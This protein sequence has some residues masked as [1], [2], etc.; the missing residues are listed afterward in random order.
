[1]PQ[2]RTFPTHPVTAGKSWSAAGR[3]LGVALIALLL[4]LLATGCSN[5]D[6]DSSTTQT[7]GNSESRSW[8]ELERFQG[9]HFIREGEG[10]LIAYA[11]TDPQ[12]P[13]CTRLHERISQGATPNVEWRW[14]PVGFLGPQSRNDAAALLGEAHADIDAPQAV[15]DNTRL[16]SG[17]GVRSV[18]TV[19]YRDRN[20]AVRAFTG[21]SPEQL[22]AL[23][24]I[25]QNYPTRD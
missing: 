15:D 8:A 12:C 18:P 5:N 6:D 19:F 17:L 4:L 20:G 10:A 13:A 23:E 21:G 7:P 9:S 2:Q 22:E 16:A 25:A 1:M 3:S 14:I 11:I 24:R